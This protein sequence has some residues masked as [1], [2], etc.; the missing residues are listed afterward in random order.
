MIQD[1]AKEYGVPAQAVSEILLPTGHPA[2]AGQPGQ[3]TQDG[4]QVEGQEDVIGQ[5][6]N[7]A[8]VASLINVINA[9]AAGALSKEGAVSVITAAFPTISREQ[10]IGIVAGIQSGKMIPTTE[11]EKQAVKDEQQDGGQGGAPVP[12][13]PKAPVAPTGLEELKCPLPTQDVK[14]N[15]ENRQTAVDKANYGPANPNEPN[16]SYWKAKANEFQGDVGTAKKM[17]C[18]NCAAFNQTSKLLGCIK[19]GIGEDAN[20][21]AL[22]GNL[23]YCEIFDFINKSLAS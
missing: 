22:G 2:Q 8:Q 21:V 11:K 10:A 3:T 17:L 18:G 7:G 13:T 20:E 12:E 9:V 4:Q 6:L 16:E 5:S 14:L 1:L 15:L 23:G 19:N